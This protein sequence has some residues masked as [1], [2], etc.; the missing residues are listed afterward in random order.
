MCPVS[1]DREAVGPCALSFGLVHV[2]CFS[3][4][5]EEIS[6]SK[7]TSYRELVSV[8]QADTHAQPRGE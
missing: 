2:L 6:P 5:R 8:C 1:V 3:I 7:V 4:M